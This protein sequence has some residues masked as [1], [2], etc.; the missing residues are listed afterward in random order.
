MRLKHNFNNNSIYLKMSFLKI[1][2]PAKRDFF[3]QEFQKTKR[4]I[5][6]NVLSEKSGNQGQQREF[7]KEFKPLLEAQSKISTELG[8]IK[9][10]STA[11]ATAL[12][13]LPASISSLK[14]VQ[15]PQYRSI[16]AYEDP[17]S[18]IRT[19]ELGDLA[20][21]Y[22]RQYA[23]RKKETDKVFGIRSTDEN[24]YIGEK[25]ISIAGDDITVGDKTYKGTPG[26]W[27]LL[28]MARPNESIYDSN[29][30][31]DYAE[32]LNVTKAMSTPSNSNKPKASGGWKYKNI[33]NPIWDA[34]TGKG[35][36]VLPQDS[37]ALVGMLDLRMFSFKAG[38]T[39]LR[40]EIVG[41][42]DELLRQ[43]VIDPESY[44]KLMV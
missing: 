4:E 33:I 26:L 7:I 5:K 30:H 15:F 3:F 29:D 13:A 22:V 20:T 39:G 11:T 10:G 23:S 42:L 21:K 6:E 40:N 27:E 17:V 16:E 41:I 28:T 24:F 37:N 9:D 32:I 8:A 31:A 2:D 44:K 35:V 12:K 1:S 38:N 14:S 43:K 19:L 36:A 34:K 18:D 25:P